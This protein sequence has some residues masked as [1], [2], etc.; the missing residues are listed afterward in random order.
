MKAIFSL[1]EKHSHVYFM[2]LNC[3]LVKTIYK[4]QKKRERERKLEM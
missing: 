3:I 2:I 1:F 4:I